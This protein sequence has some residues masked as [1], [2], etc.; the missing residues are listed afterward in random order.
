ME[1]ILPDM[2]HGPIDRNFNAENVPDC[3]GS[4]AFAVSSF[5]AFFSAAAAVI[6]GIERMKMQKRQIVTID[7]NFIQFFLY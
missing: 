5:T 7:V 2:R 4:F 6:S 1:E 3:I